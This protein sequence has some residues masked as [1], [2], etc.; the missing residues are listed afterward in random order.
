MAFRDAMLTCEM[1]GDRATPCI[2]ASWH[3]GREAEIEGW[4][5]FQ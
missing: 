1:A 2:D 4:S 5:V 3:G